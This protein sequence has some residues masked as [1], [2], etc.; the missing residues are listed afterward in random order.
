MYQFI[1]CLFNDAFLGDSDYIALKE[2]VTNEEMETMWK[3]AV[4]A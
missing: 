3:E 1:W 2:G 4:V